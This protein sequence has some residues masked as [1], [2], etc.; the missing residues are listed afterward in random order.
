MIDEATHIKLTGERWCPTCEGE[1]EMTELRLEF[2]ESL[3]F[4]LSAKKR[5]I[6]KTHVKSKTIK[7]VQLFLAG[8]FLQQDNNIS[9]TPYLHT[10]MYTCGTYAGTST[11]CTCLSS[12]LQ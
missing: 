12:Y 1:S 2:V 4:K 7:H 11:T 8:L 6:G 5:I 3:L 9:N 10:I